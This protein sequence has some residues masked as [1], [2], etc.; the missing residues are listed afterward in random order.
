VLRWIVLALLLFA[1]PVWAASLTAE[2]DA[3]TLNADG[4]PL[5]DLAGYRLYLETP[6]PSLQYAT[7]GNVTAVVIN[8]LAPSTTYTARVTAVDTSGNESECSAPASG[9]TAAASAVNPLTGPLTLAFAAD[10]AAQQLSATPSLVT[11]NK[12]VGGP[13]PPAQTVTISGGTGTWTTQD[14]N[15]WADTTGGSWDGTFLNFPATATSFGLLPSSGMTSLAAGTHTQ[16]VTVRRGTE[17]VI[18]TVQVIV[19]P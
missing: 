11:F 2:W 12:T 13:L 3:P 7:V 17:T 15:P 10:P 19:N 16:T 8:D 9:T 5:D 4:T 18:V 1:S 14:S 6:C